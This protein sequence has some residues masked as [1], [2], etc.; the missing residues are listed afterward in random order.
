MKHMRGV[1][2]CETASWSVS[3]D[4]RDFGPV[5]QLLAKTPP[6]LLLSL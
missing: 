5:R 1:M 4:Q 3:L 6:S 2:P